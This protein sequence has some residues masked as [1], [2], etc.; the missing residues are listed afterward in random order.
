MNTDDI[1]QIDKALNE[2]ANIL[3]AQLPTD[4]HISICFEE[5]EGYVRLGKYGKGE[6]ILP[7]SANKSLLEQT[8]DALEVAKADTV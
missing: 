5:G 8:L 2:L 6:M 4:Y 1:M 7:D 3:C